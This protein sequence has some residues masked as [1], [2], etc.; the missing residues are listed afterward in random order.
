M[1]THSMPEPAPPQTEITISW[2]T[3]LKILV[4]ILLTWLAVELLPIGELVFVAILLALPLWR[5]VLWARRRGWPKWVGITICTVLLLAI[6]AILAGALIPTITGQIGALI[7]KLPTVREELLKK[8]PESG[9]LRDSVNSLLESASFSDPGPL[10]K[11]F[12]AWGALALKSITQF[13]IILTLALYFLA[14]GERIYQWLL[15][16]LPKNH[17]R[18]MAIAAPEIADV[19]SQY[20]VGQLI[21]SSI[22]GVYSFIVLQ[23]LHVPSAALLGV[24]AGVLD[25]LPVIGFFV[26]FIPAVAL[27]LTVS[28]L[29]AGLVTLLYIAYN[30]VENY[31]IVPKV[32]GNQLKLS[33][34]TVLIA[35]MAGGLVGGVIG[36]IVI[37]P[38]IA[39][40]PI[41]ER[42]WLQ[43]HLEPDTVAK[44]EEIEEKE[45]PESQAAS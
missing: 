19:V 39:S 41:I 16:F 38:V 42:I 5:I 43:P 23:L 35:C 30:V 45:H 18:K 22:S 24:L 11:R 3:I 36:A 44:H 32:Y 2:G 31:F 27:A 37:L 17:R 33:T 14:D 40:Y 9:P 26:S 7:T 6:V 29:T 25:V 15:A 12:V 20:M 1:T 21:T 28:P 10:L 13:L 34:L 4:A 8:L